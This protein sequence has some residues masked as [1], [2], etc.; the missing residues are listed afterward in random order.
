VPLADA[1]AG[2]YRPSLRGREAEH[3]DPR[4]AARPMILFAGGTGTLG[5]ALVPRLVERN[6]PVRVM[7]RTAGKIE[8]VEVVTG[9]VGSPADAARAVEGAHTVVSAVTG[10]GPFRGQTSRSVDLEGN[11]T[12]FAA[13]REA[14]AE[15]V[16]LLS[17]HGAAP[18]HPIRLHRMKYAAEQDLRASGLEW[19]IVRPTSYLETWVQVLCLPLVQKGK[20]QVFGR[21]D[22]PINFVSVQ[23]VAT[24]VELAVVDPALRGRA[25]EVAGPE[26]LTM[27][28]LIERYRQDPGHAGTVNHVPRAI[29]RVSSVALRPFNPAMAE[30]IAAALV[31]DTRDIR[32]T[33]SPGATAP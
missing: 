23:E 6:L 11:R 17:V 33:G 10:L 16:V 4:A 32:P 14:G 21:G 2:V 3:G 1:R 12:L 13:A 19:T 18:D 25:I 24:T 26:D 29:M 30:L 20:T 8:G 9:D 28:E 5:S 22:T 31:M 27:N 15:H 7:T